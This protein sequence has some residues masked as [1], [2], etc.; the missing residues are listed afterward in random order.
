MQKV[1][2]L[3]NFYIAVDCPD[4]SCSG[5]GVCVEG[6]CICRKGWEGP[7]CADREAAL[8]ACLP[9]CSAPRGTFDPRQGRCNCS[10][11]YTGAD[12]SKGEDH[13]FG[14]VPFIFILIR[15][16][17]FRLNNDPNPNPIRIQGFDYQKW[18]KIYSCHC[19]GE[20]GGKA[21]R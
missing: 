18:I 3:I 11:G 10:P 15:I 1:S 14:S 17:H 20:M 5:Q 7:R 9:T 16:Q 12:C 13:D 8:S 21:E 6:A 4:P 2:L 19:V